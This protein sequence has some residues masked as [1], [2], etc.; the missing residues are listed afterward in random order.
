[1]KEC[2]PTK[3][4]RLLGQVKTELQKALS[5]APSWSFNFISALYGRKN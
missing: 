2:K 1:M 4:D 3:A 5:T